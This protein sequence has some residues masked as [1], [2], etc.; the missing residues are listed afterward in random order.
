[1]ASRACVLAAIGTLAFGAVLGPEMHVIALGWAWRPRHPEPVAS[2]HRAVRNVPVGSGIAVLAAG[3]VT[4][5][6]W[7]V[8]ITSGRR[9]PPRSLHVLG[10]GALAIAVASGA[11]LLTGQVAQVVA[12]G[13]P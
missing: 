2:S 7:I 12:L 6:A 3:V 9:E 4:V 10:S 1:M 13:T 5:A 8:R 11:W